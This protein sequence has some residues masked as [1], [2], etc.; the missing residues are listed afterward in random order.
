MRESGPD[1]PLAD[2]ASEQPNA[3]GML[4]VTTIQPFQP[5]S[6]SDASVMQAAA[7]DS[8]RRAVVERGS[9]LIVL[10]EYF[11][12]M[13]LDAEQTR[14]AADRAGELR[15]FASDFCKTNRCWL[16]LPIIE[17]RHRRYYNTA[18]L[19]DRAGRAAFQ[20]DKTHLTL[21][22][23]E[24]LGLSAG[25]RLA[26]HESELGRVGVMICYDIYFPEVARTLAQRGAQVILFPSLQRSDCAERIM[27]LN[28]ARALDAGCFL[29]RSSYGR[30]AGKAEDVR[31]GQ[32][33]G[34]SCIVAPDGR[35]LADAGPLEGFA[36]A[37]I[38]P[39][40][41]WRRPRC[42]GYAEQPV[43]QFLAD[44]RRP[45]LYRELGRRSATPARSPRLR[46]S[47]AGTV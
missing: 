28:R 25:D 32:T 12:S 22:E 21:A 43:R 36:E 3:G 17:F 47:V 34:G 5:A 1:R 26:V 42:G 39:A 46:T 37:V 24:Q 4:R 15:G 44:D 29:V 13:G 45:E 27:I 35:V 8:A 6:L 41:Q 23:R 18:I 38:E 14:W 33:H 16:L 10:P 30:Q 31:S 20:Y 2:L 11:N 40:W 9:D 19:I 7:W